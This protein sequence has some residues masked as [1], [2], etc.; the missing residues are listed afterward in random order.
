L[1][2]YDRRYENFRYILVQ[3][4][5][6][7]FLGKVDP[8]KFARSREHSQGVETV[9][10]FIRTVVAHHDVD[11][12]VESE[13]RQQVDAAERCQDDNV[14]EPRLN[15]RNNGVPYADGTQQRHRRQ[16]VLVLHH[17]NIN[18]IFVTAGEYWGFQ[19]P[20]NTVSSFSPLLLPLIPNLSFR[21]SVASLAV[22]P[23]GYKLGGSAVNFPSGFSPPNILF[24]CIS[25]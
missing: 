15:I 4:K 18:N 17:K 16:N 25:G 5:I 3:V 19:P 22:I 13:M 9:S 24:R 8:P 21:L 20:K 23:A 7:R 6:L 12:D 1:Y 11:E 2:T 10:A 14:N